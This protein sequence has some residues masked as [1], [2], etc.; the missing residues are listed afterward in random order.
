MRRDTK[1]AGGAE[2]SRAYEN[3]ATNEL[4]TAA[5]TGVG[6]SHSLDVDGGAGA[7]LSR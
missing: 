2:S 3:K 1:T 7:S 6:G 4:A 5:D